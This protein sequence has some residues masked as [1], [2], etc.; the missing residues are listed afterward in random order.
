MATLPARHDAKNMQR[1]AASLLPP[2]ALETGGAP[3]YVQVS[4]WFRRAKIGRAHV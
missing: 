1:V 2:I 4:D 3:I